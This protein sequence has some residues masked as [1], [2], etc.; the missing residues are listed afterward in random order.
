MNIGQRV[1]V[2]GL[3]VA[4]LMS[5]TGGW[6]SAQDNTLPLTETYVLKSGYSVNYPQGWVAF[7]E[8]NEVVSGSGTQIDNSRIKLSSNERIAEVGYSGDFEPGDAWLMLSWQA[9]Y[10]AGIDPSANASLTEILSRRL[11][12]DM[13]EP[14]EIQLGETTAAIAEGE[15]EETGHSKAHLIF[16]RDYNTLCSIFMYTASGEY[17]QFRSTLLAIAESTLPSTTPATASAPPAEPLPLTEIYTLKND[18]SFSYPAAWAVDY[19]LNEPDMSLA[20][21]GSNA[22]IAQQGGFGYDF[23]PGDVW[24]AFTWET[25]GNFSDVNAESNPVDVLNTSV[26]GLYPDMGDAYEIPLGD[27]TAAIAEGIHSSGKPMM[28]VFFFWDEDTIASFL[29][30]TAPDEYD[31]FKPTLL[32]IAES[33]IPQTQQAAT[34]PDTALPPIPQIPMLNSTERVTVRQWAAR[35]QATS[36]YTATDWSAQQA[37]GAPDTAGCS[38]VATAWASSDANGIETLTDFLARL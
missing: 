2:L 23:A 20:Q 36:Q 33:M 31:Q 21:L 12:A 16:F 19:E 4:L 14:Y 24:V 13:G 10:L 25:L 37:I 15:D 8:F 7:D 28:A 27:R 5:L 1:T 35:A 32:A 3:V 22:A 30:L 9:L 34:Q 11:A 17:D 18:Y 26:V 29:A 38:D 6:V